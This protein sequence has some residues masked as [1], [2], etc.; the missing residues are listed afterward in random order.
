MRQGVSATATTRERTLAGRISP[1]GHGLGPLAVF[2]AG[3]RLLRRYQVYPIIRV[4]WISF[5]DYQFPEKRA[6]ELGR[7]RHYIMAFNDPLMC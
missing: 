5:T 2:G 6:G 1:L 7:V 3:D 4:L